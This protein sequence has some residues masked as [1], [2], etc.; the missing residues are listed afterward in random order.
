MKSIER[1]AVFELEL[2]GTP[3][4]CQ[5]ADITAC[6]HNDDQ[7]KTDRITMKGFY[8][9]NGKAII[10]FMPELEGVW[11][12]TAT[13][14]EMSVK[15]S[16]RCIANQGQ[17]SLMT[18]YWKVY[19]NRQEAERV[20]RMYDEAREQTLQEIVQGSSLREVTV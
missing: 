13:W 16:F 14:G 1:Y 17:N 15:G 8:A 20:F 2:A 4:E 12:Y 5:D 9:G 19:H 6:F 3:E 10:R 11:N 18:R 7:A